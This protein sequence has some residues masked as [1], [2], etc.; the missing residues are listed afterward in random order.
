MPFSSF[1][2]PECK[3]IGVAVCSAN[4]FWNF[5]KEMMVYFFVDFTSMECTIPNDYF[6]IIRTIP[7]DF[8][9]KDTTFFRYMQIN[10][11]QI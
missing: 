5:S 9:C 7:N 8:R 10:S 2:S 6:I 3:T 1:R 11:S 4:F